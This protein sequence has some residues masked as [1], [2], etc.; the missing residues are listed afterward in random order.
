M[1]KY[2]VIIVGAGPAG[3]FAA[4]EITSLKPEAK[5]LILE[6]GP[7]VNKR[8]CPSKERGI[9]CINC[10]PCAIVT[11]WGG[12]GAVSDGKLTLSTEVGG[13]LGEY[14]GEKELNELIK[15]VDNIYL[16]FGA[17]N[18]VYGID[19]EEEIREIQKRAILADLRLV[20]APIRH[21]GTGRALEIVAAMK[22]ELLRRGVDIATNTPVAEIIADH[23]KVKGVQTTSGEYYEG[24]AV[25]VAPG[26]EGAEWLLKE[27]LKLGLKTAVNPVDI[28]VRVELPAVVLEPIT[29]V[30]YESK[31][32][33]YSKTFE[34][35]VRTF[36]MNPYGE[37][38][39]ENNDGIITVNGH[40]H[41]H[42]KTENTNFALLVSKTFTHPFKEPIAYGKYIARLANLLGGGVLVQRLGD[43]MDG[44]RT[45]E[46]RL[47][48]GLVR[49]TLEDATP[50]DLSLVFPYRHLMALVEMLQ[51][52]DKIAP[53]VFNRNTL[54]Y[55]VEVKFYSSRLELSPVLETKI[56]NLFAA[57][58]GAGVTRGL[59]QASASGVLIGR[60][61][62]RR[63]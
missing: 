54:L 17:P 10:K 27:S 3:I 34:D 44:R 46:E 56:Q 58:D 32:I 30:V 51:A 25:I 31:F 45:T 38:V 59:I 49:P 40:S 43:L 60:E 28:G 55:G 7:D 50:G 14:I 23:G 18:E 57:G 1:K 22:E 35:K 21:L 29:K 41:A 8:I 13:H 5:V 16:K 6:K 24:E 62:A 63:L 15:Y 37:V 26:R 19:R 36:C 61:L 20:P 52:L 12:A 39:Q 9:P 4:L 53:G 42:K 33:Y 47:K 48:K 2:D 11:G